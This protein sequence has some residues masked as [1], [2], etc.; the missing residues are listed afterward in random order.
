MEVVMG[1]QP[2]LPATIRA[3]LRTF[4]RVPLFYYLIHLP[5]LHLL[6]LIWARA[7][8]GTSRIPRTEPLDLALI[9]GAWIGASAILYWPCRIYDRRKTIHRRSWMRYL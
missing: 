1:I 5:F 4:G 7:I 8:H 9:Y 6:G 3:V 2:E